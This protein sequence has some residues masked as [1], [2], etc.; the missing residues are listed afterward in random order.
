MHSL[1]K[2]ACSRI[3]IPVNKVRFVE[4][5]VRI[6]SNILTSK[7][8]EGPML[9]RHSRLIALARWWIQDICSHLSKYISAHCYLGWDYR[10]LQTNPDFPSA[11]PLCFASWGDVLDCSALVGPGLVSR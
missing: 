10:I 3:I 7:Y 6:F 11:G 5:D 9:F 2:I 4:R 1:L 8:S